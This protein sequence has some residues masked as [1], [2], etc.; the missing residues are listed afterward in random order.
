MLRL[1]ATA[2]LLDKRLVPKGGCLKINKFKDL[3][4]DKTSSHPT[5]Y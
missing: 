3:I 4:Y 5:D 2:V 1:A